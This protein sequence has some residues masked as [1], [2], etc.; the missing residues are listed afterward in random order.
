[1]GIVGFSKQLKTSFR[2]MFIKHYD[3]IWAAFS[4]VDQAGV[5]M[6]AVDWIKNELAGVSWVAA[7]PGQPNVAIVGRHSRA[8]LCLTED[9]SISL[10]H[11]AVIVDPAVT[12]DRGDEV[13]Y[14]VHDLRTREGFCDEHD[15]ELRGLRVEGPAFIRVGHYAVFFL[16]TGDPTDWP[17]HA[18]NA[19]SYLP[20]R[21]Y[22]EERFGDGTG[23]HGHRVPELEAAGLKK[24]KP[25]RRRTFL[26]TTMGPRAS[27]ANLLRSDENLVGLLK[28][29]TAN[30]SAAL[31]VGSAAARDGILLGRYERCAKA[32]VLADGRISR[33]HLLVI[34]IAGRL[35]AIDVA[36]SCGTWRFSS[37]GSLRST[38]VQELTPHTKL[39]LADRVAEV[40]WVP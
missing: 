34:E 6:V 33:V 35:W 20:E 24:R 5:A 32:N 27:G 10:R 14:S 38:R 29:R 37:N 12:W 13:A 31:K 23:S 7:K 30:K 28:I 16:T 17:A 9:P 15:R 1:M 21:V 3:A 25:G 2:S 22:L 36:S 18:K 4:N 39:V 40:G 8:D 11:L 19:W 26:Q